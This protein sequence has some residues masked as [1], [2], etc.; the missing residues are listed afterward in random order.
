MNAPA[1]ELG[2]LLNGTKFIPGACGTK[3]SSLGY[4]CSWAGPQGVVLHWSHNVS[5]PPINRYFGYLLGYV[6][7]TPQHRTVATGPTAKAQ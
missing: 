1:R 5:H 4:Q 6:L 3:P 2:T 7:M